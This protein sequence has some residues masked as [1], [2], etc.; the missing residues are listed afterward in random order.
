MLACHGGQE[1]CLPLTVVTGSGPSLLVR[2]WLSQLQIDLEQVCHISASALESLLERKKKL[3]EPGLG[4]LKG[5]RAKIHVDPA[6][7][8]KFCKARL[9]PYAMHSEVEELEHLKCP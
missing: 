8:S 4:K 3:F 6:A 7:T 2:D 1:V 5:F 9:V